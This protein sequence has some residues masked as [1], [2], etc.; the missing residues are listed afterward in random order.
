MKEFKKALNNG[1]FHK[2]SKEFPQST[3]ENFTNTIYTDE[4]RN[5]LILTKKKSVLHIS[6]G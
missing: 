5:Y 2:K 3:T 4:L 1:H 6:T